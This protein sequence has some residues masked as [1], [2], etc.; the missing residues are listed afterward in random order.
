MPSRVP[1]DGE[2]TGDELLKLLATLANPHRMRIVG[3]L[4]GGRFYVSELARELGISRPLLQAHLRR[5]QA[6]GL[7]W[8]TVELDADGRAMKYYELSPF[9]IRL[10]ARILAAAVDTLTLPARDATESE[11]A[12]SAGAEAPDKGAT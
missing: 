3:A 5:M 11:P 4:A 9:V 12:E 2:F 10:D 8:A 6:V 7:V 1:G